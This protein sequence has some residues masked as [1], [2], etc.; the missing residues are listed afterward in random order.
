MAKISM[1]ASG[2]FGQLLATA[3]NKKGISLRELAAK[4]DYT[5][6][7][8]RKLWTGQSAPSPLLLKELARV[9][10]MDLKEAERASTADRMERKY[11]KAAYGVLGRD[12]RLADIEDLIPQL[13]KTEWDMFVSQMRGFVQQKR[14]S[15]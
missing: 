11:G 7:Q 8:M 5:Y 9:L 3:V 4:L 10:D 1:E 15:Q 2:R 6:E 12:P 13:S 14:K